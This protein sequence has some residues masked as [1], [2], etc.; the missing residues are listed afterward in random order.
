MEVPYLRDERH[1]LG[2]GLGARSVVHE[3]GRDRQHEDEREHG[4]GPSGL[5]PRAEGHGDDHHDKADVPRR[6]DDREEA[7]E[8]RVEVTVGHRRADA[9]RG[10][11]AG[12][13]PGV[14]DLCLPREAGAPGP[15]SR[16]A[17]KRHAVGRGA[18]RDEEGERPT[19]LPDVHGHHQQ[20]DHR[21]HAE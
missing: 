11:D 7:V 13:D 2:R 19:W 6:A 18:D 4:Q 20:R 3:G 1:V 15:R 16:K 12:N 10:P 21:E 14:E 5:R 17:G 9:D 8:P